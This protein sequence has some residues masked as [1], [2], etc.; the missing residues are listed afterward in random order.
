MK[1]II[2]FTLVLI[3][4]L[5]FSQQS[6]E[7]I[8][9]ESRKLA[10]KLPDDLPEEMK[11]K[12]PKTSDSKKVLK[13]NKEASIYSN[14]EKKKEE[15]SFEHNS[16]DGDS[17]M[18]IMIMQPQEILFKNLTDAKYIEQKD[19]MGKNFLIKDE[20]KNYT[21]KIS[22]EQKTI[23]DF[24]CMKATTILKKDTITAWFTMKIPVSTGPGHLGKLPGLVLE[25]SYNQGERT[26]VATKI[27]LKPMA[28]EDFVAPEKGK[29]IEADKYEVLAEEKRKEM[30]ENGGMIR[31][32]IIRN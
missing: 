19:L 1:K 3:P 22:A 7:I 18:K 12:I 28:A 6:G 17:Q 16:E 5:S 24:P 21:W 31:R 20:L 4:F 13:F 29:E 14:F 10:I 23:L 2:I 32:E 30:R 8:F 15:K 9:K 11:M 27:D 25:A 26:V